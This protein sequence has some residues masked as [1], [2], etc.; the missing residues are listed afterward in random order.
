MSSA[1]HRLRLGRTP[2]HFIPK[3]CCLP[4]TTGW[5]TMGGRGKTIK[6]TNSKS[7]L[8]TEDAKGHGSSHCWKKELQQSPNTVAMLHSLHLQVSV[9]YVLIHR[10]RFQPHLPA[11]TNV[12]M[13][14]ETGHLHSQTSPPNKQKFIFSR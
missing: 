6:Q 5:L 4:N 14:T 13:K 7:E 3:Y 10:A 8:E 11:A 2:Q 1:K 12:G 9:L